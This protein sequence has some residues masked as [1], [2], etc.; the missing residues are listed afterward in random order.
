MCNIAAGVWRNYRHNNCNICNTAA[1]VCGNNRPNIKPRT[2]NIVAG[3]GGSRRHYNWCNTCNIFSWCLRQLSAMAR[4]ETL[5]LMT[6]SWPPN[7]VH[8]H[9]VSSR[10]L[11]PLLLLQWNLWWENTVSVGPEF[12]KFF[13]FSS[14]SYFYS[15]ISDERVQSFFQTTFFFLRGVVRFFL[16]FCTVETSD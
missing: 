6:L 5:P 3:V 8:S 9:Q 4:P 2:C 10:R 15:G 11:W 13:G 14:S 16:Q 7:R 12:G 1:G